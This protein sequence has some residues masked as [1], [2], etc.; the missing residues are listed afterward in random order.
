MRRVRPDDAGEARAHGWRA[1]IVDD[2]D[3]PEPTDVVL[4]CPRCG[5]REFGPLRRS[6]LEERD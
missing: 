5:E 2:P 4:Y 3:E 6:P 1:F